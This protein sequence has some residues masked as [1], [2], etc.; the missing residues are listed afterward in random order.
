MNPV[1]ISF[2]IQSVVRMGRV[3]N[4]ALEQWARD[5][6]AIFPEINKPNFNKLI[7]ISGFFN[8]PENR[9]FVIGDRAVYAEYWDNTAPKRDASSQDALFTAVT[10]ITAERGGDLNQTLAPAAAILVKQWDKSA[11]PV[12]PWARIILTAGD[13]ALD[14][15]A[16]NPSI[17]G[18]NG[19]GEKMIAAYARNLSDLL[20]DNGQFGVKEGFVQ[21]LSGVFLR[22]GLSTL[23]DHPEWVV[24]ESHVTE[25]INATVTPLLQN[26]PGDITTQLIW[27]DVADTMMGAAASAALQTVA[28]H[29]TAF[30]GNDFIPDKAL[31]AVTRALFL[32]AA[33][34]GI[35][36]QFTRDGLLG[37][38]T[39]ALG[40]AAEQPDLFIGDVSK[41][42]DQFS[43]ELFSKLLDVLQESPPPFDGEVGIA[44]AGAAIE[45]AG[46]NA[47][48]LASVDEPWEQAAADMVQ[49]LAKNL[50]DALN[51]NGNIKNVFSK[52]QLTELGRIVLTQVA[53]TP[54]MVVSVQN[55]VWDGVIIAVASAMKADEK[56]LLSGD[57]WL[58]IASVAAEEAA[59]NPAR[60][61]RLDP[62]K[63]N[64]VLAGT[65]LTRVLEAAGE[66]LQKPD[67]MTGNVLYGKTLRVA[68]MV[69]LRNASGNPEAVREHLDKI[70]ELIT[71][72]NEFV[73]GNTEHY[74]NKE[75]IRLFRVLLSGVLE[76]RAIPV[77]DLEQADE[78][79]KGVM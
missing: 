23:N 48:R 57:D 70:T 51:T 2:G 22:A 42:D 14:Y 69:M 33:E 77:L 64:E 60:L 40:V 39:A 61:F 13:I 24:S 50:N 54:R 68:I 59:A 56:L 7:F 21:R 66:I 16:A 55:E 18:G 31:G 58:Q 67:L 46:A 38:Y 20:P 35:K 12:S 52:G 37:L 28:K 73:A 4:A 19:S 72:L 1:L 65:L 11:G 30:M 74:G 47:H 76:G 49:S 75:W 17:L 5:D 36:D 79:L 15:V 45:V 9:H 41:P 34:G 25:L 8:K 62:D 78:I 10:K 63:P 43:R 3:T 44:L 32:E 27:Q 6:E 26:M 53:K 71:K 29:Q